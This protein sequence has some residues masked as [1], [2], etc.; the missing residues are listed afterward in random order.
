M[1][2][3]FLHFKLVDFLYLYIKGRINKV[4]GDEWGD[5]VLL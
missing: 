5:W 3:Y 2:T 4:K 1:L